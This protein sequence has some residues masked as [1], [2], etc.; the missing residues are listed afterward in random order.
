MR[1]KYLPDAML[2]EPT[3][4]MLLELFCQFAGGASMSTK[5]LCIAAEC[6]ESTALRHIDRLEES[7]LIRRFRSP[8]DG[9]VTL[10]DL[11]KRGVVG[12]GRVLER[13]SI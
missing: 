3:W 6:P 7:G 8:A 11:T 4:N 9:R 10:A 2:G 1:N 12:I 13:V 5:S